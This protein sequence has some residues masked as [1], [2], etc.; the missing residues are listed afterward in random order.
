M[1][2]SLLGVV[3]TPMGWIVAEKLFINSETQLDNNPILAELVEQNRSPYRGIFEASKSN[4]N[5]INILDADLS[6]PRV[7]FEQLVKPFYAIFGGETTARE[8][9]Y[10]AFGSLWSLVVWSFAGLAITRI[11]LLRFTRNER[12]GIDDALEYSIGFFSDVFFQH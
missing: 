11:C 4:S 10:F 12:A 2:F 6:G 3:A 8:F 1:V 7:V 9:L 5:K